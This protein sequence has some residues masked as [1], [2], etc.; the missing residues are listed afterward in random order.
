MMWSFRFFPMLL[1]LASA[2]MVNSKCGST[3][4]VQVLSSC[5]DFSYRSPPLKC[6]KC[7]IS[8]W[9]PQTKMQA[10]LEELI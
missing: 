6:Y 8:K 10:C 9:F 4:K 7:Q 3:S 2:G 1:A 5:F